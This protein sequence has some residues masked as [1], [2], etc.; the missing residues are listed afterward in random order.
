VSLARIVIIA[1][2]LALLPA[3][4]H[5]PERRTGLNGRAPSPSATIVIHGTKREILARRATHLV[6]VDGDARLDRVTISWAH[7]RDVVLGSGTAQL[8]VHFAT[9]RVEAA[10]W[11]VD[12]WKDTR[13]RH[14]MPWLGATNLDGL[15]G[16]ELLVGRDIGA[17]NTFFKVFADDG[18]ALRVLP[19]PPHSQGW[20]IG[21]SVGTGT[22][23]IGC[24]IGK[25]AVID[26]LPHHPNRMLHRHDYLVST[27]VYRWS[28]T[29]W[30]IVSR[31][32]HV[33]QMSN[34]LDL[35]KCRGAFLY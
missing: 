5:A 31:A 13:R 7:L 27:T 12:T 6:D 23:V 3:C 20:E 14:S 24:P 18:R 16:D 2:T 1:A 4:T 17:S 34:G 9:G 25:V 26:S 22:Q 32:S 29:H 19:P 28:W 15:P 30:H 33:G 10:G 11:R 35:A 21:G 8:T